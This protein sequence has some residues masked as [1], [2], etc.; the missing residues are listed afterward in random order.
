MK[1]LKIS[2]LYK[3]MQNFRFPWRFMSSVVSSGL[4][5][6]VLSEEVSD[7][8]KEPKRLYINVYVCHETSI[9]SPPQ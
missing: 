2:Y 1:W 6:S 3:R 4:S 5:R 7:V 9:N 8:S